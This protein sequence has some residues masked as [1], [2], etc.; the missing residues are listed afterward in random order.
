MNGMM[1]ILAMLISLAMM[2]TGAGEGADLSRT[3][4]IS[5]LT[6]TVNDESVTLNPTLSL[7]A[8]S[9]GEMGLF[10]LALN[11]NGEK[12]F[13]V[14]LMADAEKLTAG[15]INANTAFSV[16]AEALDQLMQTSMD[17]AN[18]SLEQDPETAKLLQFLTQELLPAYVDVI[19]MAQDPEATKAL[20]DNAN[21]KFAELIDRG[22]GAETTMTL[23]ETEYAVTEY[24]YTMTT[25]D[26][27][28]VAEAVYHSN[29]KLANLYDKLFEFYGML[30]EESGLTNIH[31]F[32]DL[33]EQTG[34][35]MSAEV[36]ER[37]SEA[38][39]LDDMDMVMT[40]AVPAQQVASVE[41]SEGTET[42]TE[43]TQSVETIEF[44]P[45]VMN[46]HSTK[47]GEKNDA[48]VIM[49]YVVEDE[50]SMTMDMTANMEG[51][52]GQSMM[53]MSVKADDVEMEMSMNYNVSEDSEDVQIMF[54]ATN[55]DGSTVEMNMNAGQV[56]TADGGSSYLVFGSVQATGDDDGGF[57]F[58][59]NGDQAADG[60]SVND[61]AVI[62][63]ADDTHMELDFNLN[64]TDEVIEDAVSGM[65]AIVIDDLEN[66][67]NITED[68]TFAGSAAQIMGS[69][70]TD[71]GKL[72]NDESVQELLG[73]FTAAQESLTEEE[74][75]REAEEE[76]GD[77]EDT[78]EY[79]EPEDDG[80]L[81]FN[82][83]EF[84]YLPEGWSVDEINMDTVY[85]NVDMTIVNEN[86]DFVMNS[87]FYG[88]YDDGSVPYALDEDGNLVELPRKQVR[89]YD[90]GDGMWNVDFN[91]ASVSGSLYIYSDTV[92]FEEIGKVVAGLT[93]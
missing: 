60:T 42:E 89:V 35:D 28:N 8:R 6:L 49:D 33:F 70:Y 67:D 9:D 11:L 23:G 22:E 1:S 25:E 31:S 12:L 37:V 16:P 92:T 15:L 77:Y 14:Q 61:V 20:Q 47:L 51:V 17:M 18:A 85:D 46:I 86:G 41:V 74:T 10:D 53:S 58:A 68:E 48:Q 55:E 5:D 54:D 39:D 63:N 73:L 80:V 76:T 30:P 43:E 81:A 78:Y 75:T 88:N 65:N 40:I 34:V 69:V 2:L 72:M 52:Y 45:M 93:Y 21:A 13:P 19:E 36:S 56:A 64:V 4:T 24:Q 71:A 57:G 87:Y 79:E 59:I 90:Q 26:M 3:M 91:D 66:L 62:V 7:G 44:P 82:Q 84:T 50:V 29:D 83:P 32:R 27:I 38:D